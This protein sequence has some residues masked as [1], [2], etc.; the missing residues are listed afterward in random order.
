MTRVKICG[1]TNLDDALMAV[2]CG[3]EELGF[4]FYEKSPRYISPV[5][6][7]KI[8][9]QLPT[10]IVKIGLF[11]NENKQ[12]I[13]DVASVAS[14]SAIQLHGDESRELMSTLRRTTGLKLI[15]AIRVKPDIDFRDGLDF[16]A[17]FILLDSF[18]VSEYGGSGLRFDWGLI[19]GMQTLRPN[20][21]LAGG[22]TPKNV[23]KAI[24]QVQPYA[25]DVASGVETSP[26]EKDAVK[27]RQFIEAAK[28]AQ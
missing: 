3:A 5:E 13:C 20:L 8:I 11:V 22:L 6:A 14:L 2:E 25:V 24:S 1:I 9:G 15:K 21:Y 26:G 18:S 7:A 28:N 19:E 23:A 16:D 4:N 27:V 10:E 12:R 17:D